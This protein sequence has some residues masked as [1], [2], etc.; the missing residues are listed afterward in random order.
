MKKIYYNLDEMLT[1]IEEPNGTKCREIWVQNAAIFAAAK[2]SA[3]KH[4]AWEGGYLDHITEVMNIAII[5]YEALDAC[6]TLP[7]ALSD[8]LLTLFLH[9]LEKPWKYGGPDKKFTD[10]DDRHAF[11]NSLIEKFKIE[12]T[13]KHKNALKYVHGECDDWHPEIIKQGPLGAFVH[14]C[15]NTSARIWNQE[16]KM[17]GQW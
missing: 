5:M 13:S 6:R 7:F 1:M 8:A 4:Q 17:R 9:D 14:H 16:P 10:D 2:G 11:V 3:T 12:L 15:D